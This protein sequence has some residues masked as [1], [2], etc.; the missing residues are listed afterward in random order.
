MRNM[1]RRLHR[2]SVSCVIQR[3]I[4]QLCPPEQL[5]VVYL[6]QFTFINL[7]YHQTLSGTV[8]EYIIKNLI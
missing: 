7:P 1:C 5:N 6:L 2:V 3:S 8:N 4:L